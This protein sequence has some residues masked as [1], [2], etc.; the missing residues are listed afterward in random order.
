MSAVA[1]R[2]IGP[3]MVDG[4]VL[5]IF[6]AWMLT[7]GGA[8]LDAGGMAWLYFG[9]TVVACAGSVIVVWTIGDGHPSHHAL[10]IVLG[11]LATSLALFVG[12]VATGAL[13]ATVFLGWSALVIG[14]LVWTLRAEPDVERHDGLDILAIAVLA[15]LVAAWCHRAAGALHSIETAGIVPIW[16]DYSIHATEIAQFGDTDLSKISSFLLAGQPLVFY[17][18]LSYMLPA[19]VV[20]VTTLPPW[21]VA[22][23]V[24]LPYG[25]LL[26]SVGVFALVR[27]RLGVPTAA[28]VPAALVLIPDASSYG[29]RNGFFG[30]HWMLFTSPGSGYALSA[31]FAALTLMAIWRSLNRSPCFWLGIVVTAAAFGFRAQVFM[32]LAPALA[33]TLL[34][35]TVWVQRH[36]RGAAVTATLIAC[37]LAITV[38]T[39]D[40]ARDAW[41]QFSAFPR[42]LDAM[43]SAQSPTAYDG[44]YRAITERYG[45]VVA[46]TI[47]VVALVPAVLGGLVFALPLAFA[48]AA[49]RTGWRA[50]DTFPVWCL[51]AWLGLVLLAPSAAHGDNTEFQHRPFVL[52]YASAFVWTF[53]FTTRALSTALGRKAVGLRRGLSAVLV[54]GFAIGALAWRPENPARP[55]FAWGS[56]YFDTTVKPGIV[57]AATF[58]RT[59]ATRGDMFALIPTD[60]SARLDDDATELAALA[61]VPAYLARASIQATNGPARKA[62]VEQRLSELHGVETG[63][64]AG[65]A[66]ATLR[67]LGV[68]FLVALGD[69]GPLFDPSGARAAFRT[70]GA[71][72]YEIRSEP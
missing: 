69:H 17:H 65:A 59:H 48:V 9:G 13:A 33:A 21:G 11:S 46:S 30:F 37:A 54:A 27:T 26:M 24:L 38:A 55:R 50:L 18:Y 68:D 58:V 15:V 20:A 22:A 34:C 40:G 63:S 2:L 53:L 29:L 57:G 31:A 7:V 41:L 4:L 6:A 23:S 35:E 25:I 60:S 67:A 56:N 16:S 32:V 45:P 72:V 44:V 62:V 1:R 51:A 14:A 36:R 10:A 71:V 66:F 5:S 47:G 52:V 49:Q 3:A 12:C 61:G 19:A 42:S 43:H 64:D 39:W 8:T 70:A 28:V